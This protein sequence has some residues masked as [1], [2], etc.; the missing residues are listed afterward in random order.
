MK[1]KIAKRIL[2]TGAGGYIG[3]HV[4]TTLLDKGYQVY[5]ADIKTDLIDERAIKYS[6]SIFSGEKDIFEKLG[7]PDIC[8]HMAWRDGFIHNSDVHIMDLNNHYEF[9]K[10]M[11]E[12]GLKHIVVMGTM[13][14][15]GYWEGEIDETTPTNP[16]SLYGI[17][18]NALRQMVQLLVEQHEEVTYQW[19]R[20]FYICGDDLKN[21]SIFAKIIK[22]EREGQRTFPFTAGTNKYDFID[23]NELAYQIAMASIQ[24]K[25]VGIINC[26]TGNAVSLKDK[27][28][29]FLK[30]NDFKITPEYGKFPN[31]KYDSPEIW[32]SPKKIREIIG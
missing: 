24:D 14:E 15:I 5:A 21:N 26:C 4:V 1:N 32:G 13:H 27:V 30:D 12:G 3:R 23:V 10:N 11:I 29:E 19:L 17:A 9:I 20:A 7:C 6:N 25:V 2:V 8:I 31:R 16:I 22:M 28:E 18:K